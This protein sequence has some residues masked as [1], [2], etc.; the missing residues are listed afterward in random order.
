M[1][2]ARKLVVLAGMLAIAMVGG[3]AAQGVPSPQ[4]SGAVPGRVV[5]AADGRPLAGVVVVARWP[6]QPYRTGGFHSSAGYMTTGEAIHVGEDVTGADGRF[7]IAAW[8][9]TLRGPGRMGER[10]PWVLAFKGGYEPLALDATAAR[11]PM[12]LRRV[13]GSAAEQ[14][15]AI[16]RFQ[17]AAEGVPSLRWRQPDDGWRDIPRMV[18]ALHRE[19]ARLGPEGVAV[20]GAHLLNGRAGHG[21]LVIEERARAGPQLP[22]ILIQWRLRRVD[23]A[24][25]TI[26]AWQAKRGG[27]DR[28]SRGFYVSPWRLPSVAPAGWEIDPDVAPIVRGYAIDHRHGAPMSWPETGATLRLEKLPEERAAVVAEVKALRHDIDGALGT[29]PD[30]ARFAALKPILELLELQCRELTADLRKGACFDPSSAVAAYLERARREPSM[31]TETEEDVR[32][33]RVVGIN[34]EAGRGQAI[35]IQVPPSGN[36]LLRVPVSGFSIEPVRK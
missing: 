35:G 15:A 30:E 22:V 16:A 29:A 21:E 19:K 11:E 23:G 7:R 12:R 26:T 4:F 5:D 24:P 34:L 17:W 20:L 33:M 3:V 31:A 25:G 27:T 32:T 2:I 6:W 36:P 18:L 14:A 28:S 10:A 8:G 13:G 9:P 1:A